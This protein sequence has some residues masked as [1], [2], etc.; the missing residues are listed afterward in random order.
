[1]ERAF[2]RIFIIMLENE[3]ESTVRQDPFMLDLETK[4]VRLSDYHGVAHPSQP[5]YIAAIAGVPI[6]VDDK[7]KDIDRQNLVDL[8]EVKGVSWKAYLEDLPEDNKAVCISQDRLYFRKHNPYVPFDNNRNNP[9]RLAKIVNARQLADDLAENAVPEF[10]WYTPNIQNDGH[11]PPD[12]SNGDFAGSVAFLSK[13]LQEFLPPLLNNADFMKGTLI[14]I[15][16]DE[17]I[18]HAD[19]QVYTTLL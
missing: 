12:T 5:N 4:G 2:D 16:F 3:L 18:P 10:C 13:F 19:N 15:T 17:S 9:E 6:L 8:L 14:V 7:C 11:S 1:M